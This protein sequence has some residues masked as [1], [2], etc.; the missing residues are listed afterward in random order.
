[1]KILVLTT[2]TNN[3][4]P[5]YEP[6][7]RLGHQ[8]QVI[9]YDQMTREHQEQLPSIARKM[10]PAWILMIDAIQK[11]YPKP[12]PHVSVLA[13]LGEVAPLVN[14][15]CDGIEPEWW[16]QIDEYYAKGKFALQVNIDGVRGG[17]IGRRGVTLVCPIDAEAWPLVPWA[18]RKNWAAFSGGL[19]GERGDLI[20]PLVTDGTI[21]FRP[22]DDGPYEQY[23]KFVLEGRIGV[24]FPRTGGMTGEHVKARIFEYAAGQCLVIERAGSPLDEWFDAPRNYLQYTD[25]QDLRALIAHVK[26]NPAEY[27]EMALRFRNQVI[28]NHSPAVF[29]SQIMERIGIGKAL[30]PIREVAYRVPKP[31]ERISAGVTMTF[32]P[33]APKAGEPVRLAI[34]GANTFADRELLNMAIETLHASRPIEVMLD[35]GRHRVDG[36]AREWAH[37][38]GIK[39]ISFYDRIRGSMNSIGIA[40]RNMLL[41]RYGNPNI[42]MTFGDDDGV[43]DMAQR[44]RDR[45]I[46]IIQH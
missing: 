13:Q 39:W 20:P 4:P 43:R 9:K 40:Q 30:R 2:G 3:T 29:Y 33:T 28:A 44:C 32:P 10:S 41:L 11:H 36:M 42:V 17:P 24:G 19:W 31:S 1:M 18:K 15:V 25:H 7:R 35:A 12:V 46:A 14:M 38:R 34:I 5:L 6:L 8:L 22:R 45:D 21:V 27:E 23:I 26:A 37:R 16:P